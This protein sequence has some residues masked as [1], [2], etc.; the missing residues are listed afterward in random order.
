MGIRKWNCNNCK[1]STFPMMG[2]KVDALILK[3]LEQ[4]R[5]QFTI[6]LAAAGGVG[7]VCCW[8]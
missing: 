1:A 3:A 8:M 4:C 2:G 6:L 5:C 7:P